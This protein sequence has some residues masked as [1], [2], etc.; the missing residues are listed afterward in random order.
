[1][2]SDDEFDANH[3]I[4]F[5]FRLEGKT[6]ELTLGDILILPN[7]ELTTVDVLNVEVI[8]ACRKDVNSDH[9]CPAYPFHFHHATDHE[10]VI[11]LVKYNT[12]KALDHCS[13]SGF[14]EKYLQC[15]FYEFNYLFYFRELTSVTVVCMDDPTMVEAI[16]Y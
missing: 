11:A 1:M 14:K 16:G 8:E 12:Q 15:H 4:P 6:V 10:C 7:V 2:R 13:Y 5:P 9:I 3:L